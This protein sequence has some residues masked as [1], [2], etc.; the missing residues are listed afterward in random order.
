MEGFIFYESFAEAINLLPTQDQL[1]A[2]KAIIAYGLYGDLPEFDS[3]AAQAIFIM[4][5]PQMDANKKRRAGGASG[6]RP[7][8]ETYGYE[9]EKPMVSETETYGFETEKP[10]VSSFDENEKPKEKVKEKVK[11]KDK[12]KESSSKEELKKESAPRFVPPS[13]EE[14]AAYCRERGNNVDAQQFVDFYSSK[15]WKVGKEPMKD[16]KACVRT[17]EKRERARSGTNRFAAGIISSDYSGFKEE[18]L[19]ANGDTWGC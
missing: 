3:N 14:V 2:Y 4:A 8:K 17:W 18:D 16:W 1:E 10:M 7:K 15:G 12:E 9:N 13:V 6:G 19:I 5:R 11:V